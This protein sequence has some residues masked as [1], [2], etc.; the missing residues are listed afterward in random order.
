MPGPHWV[1]PLVLSGPS[2]TGKSTLLKR[3]FGEHPGLFAFSVSHT[4]RAP[5]PGEVNGSHYHFVTRDEFNSLLSQGGFVE[6]AEFS[7]NL[8]GT[9]KQAISTIIESGKRCILDIE[10]QGVRQIRNT[11]LNPVYCFIAPPSLS[12]LR[13]R[14]V[15][16]GTEAQAAVEKRLKTAFL[17]ID[18]AKVP[19]AHDCIIVNDNLDRAYELFEAVAFGDQISGDL[20]PPLDD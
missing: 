12:T 16:R 8:Y 13:E 6:H 1:R 9:S 19:G 5:R 20:L 10:V 15:G 11:D 17:E 18:Y 4:T 3:L 14:L 7:G 2:G